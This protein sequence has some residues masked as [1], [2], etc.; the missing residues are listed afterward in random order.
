MY[1]KQ[2]QKIKTKFFEDY[3]DK[4]EDLPDREQ[5][6]KQMWELFLKYFKKNPDKFF[7]PTQNK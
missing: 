1:D 6:I 4:F 7:K 2:L 5:V 3:R